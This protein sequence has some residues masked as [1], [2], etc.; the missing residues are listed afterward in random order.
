MADKVFKAERV[1]ASYNEQFG[2][3]RDSQGRIKGAN[4]EIIGG[5]MKVLPGAIAP[6]DTEIE[7]ECYK[8]EVRAARSGDNF[9]ARPK[10]R[11]FTMLDDAEL[12]VDKRVSEM[13]KR[14]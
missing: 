6:L 8:V 14:A 5:Y 4:V 7:G 2:N 9:G 11:F 1:V 3:I 13:K 10:T 12:F